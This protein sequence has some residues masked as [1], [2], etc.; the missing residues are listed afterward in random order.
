MS[1]GFLTLGDVAARTGDLA[2]ACT[3]C[4]RSGRYRV[5][6]LVEQHGAAFPVPELLRQLSAN[7]P[8]RGSVSTYDLCGAHFPE[9]SKLFLSG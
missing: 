7:C 4:D 3:R 8:K 6:R 5:A 1:S 9:L 2:G